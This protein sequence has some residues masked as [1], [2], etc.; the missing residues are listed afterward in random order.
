MLH[1]LCT[2]E[3]ALGKSYATREVKRYIVCISDTIVT[4]SIFNIAHSFDS[5]PLLTWALLIELVHLN[6]P[7]YIAVDL[8]A[9]I[10]NL[11]SSI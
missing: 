10:F 6:E 9:D 5:C 1:S 7:E 11:Y 8:N 2:I 3:N 4:N